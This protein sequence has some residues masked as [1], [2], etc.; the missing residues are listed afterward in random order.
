MAKLI[1]AIEVEH[2]TALKIEAQARE[3]H[4][5]EVPDGYAPEGF[6]NPDG[7]IAIDSSEL[8]EDPWD[9]NF[10]TFEYRGIEFE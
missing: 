4:R 7:R 8:E 10:V 6:F 2:N 9:E 5:V 3:R 1:V